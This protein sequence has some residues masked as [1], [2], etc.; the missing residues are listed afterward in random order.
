MYKV[1][2]NERCF[3]LSDK[4]ECE[5]AV[6]FSGKKELQQLILDFESST[7]SELCV[8]HSDIPEL[9]EK[10]KS[11]FKYIEAAG[12]LVQND[13]KEILFIYRLGKWDLP[14]GKKEKNESIENTALRE[15][16]EETG[17]KNLNLTKHLTDTYHT[18]RI[19]NNIVLKKTYWYFMNC[20]DFNNLKPQTEEN[21]SELK[22]IGKSDLQLIRSNTYSSI[23]DVLNQF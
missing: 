12:G 20:N 22:W 5:N 2:F 23:I 17:A 13:V 14:K 3:Y 10:F 19:K 18:Y 11:F 16:M 7:D 6:S 1:F 9:F 4:A 8:I 15:V 21:I